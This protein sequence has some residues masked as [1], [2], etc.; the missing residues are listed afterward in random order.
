MKN[1]KKAVFIL[2]LALTCGAFSS[3]AQIIVKIR[4]PRPPVQR[5]AP[6]SPIHIW[7]DEDWAPRGNT[8][9]FRGGRWEEPPHPNATWVPGHWKQTHD[10]YIWVPGQW[11][12]RPGSKGRGNSGRQDRIHRGK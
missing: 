10:G 12:T 11:R 2:G 8:Y 1:I 6:P 3:M 4:P 7:I 9:E 5:P